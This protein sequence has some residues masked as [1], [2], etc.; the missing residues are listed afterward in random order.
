VP[1]TL[2]SRSR[3]ETQTSV[4]LPVGIVAAQVRALCAA[5]PAGQ[6]GERPGPRGRPGT[7]DVPS[8]TLGLLLSHIGVTML[9]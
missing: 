8:V 3:S 2:G 5:C 1:G 6:T 7:L 9:H 4:L